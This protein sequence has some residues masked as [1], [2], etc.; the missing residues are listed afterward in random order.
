MVSDISDVYR[1]ERYWK[2]C[3]GNILHTC[4]SWVAW[5]LELN[6]KVQQASDV[7]LNWNENCLRYAYAALI[8]VV[9]EHFEILYIKL[10]MK[11]SVSVEEGW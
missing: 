10:C 11:G 3:E 6:F 5:K 1:S 7:V 9:S 8:D 2:S 4:A